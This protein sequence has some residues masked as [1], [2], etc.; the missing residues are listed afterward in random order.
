MPTRELK[1]LPDQFPAMWTGRKR[2]EFR[3]DDRGYAVGNLLD[4]REWD[5]ATTQHTGF[6]LTAR[7]THLARGPAYKIPEGFAVLS[8]DQTEARKGYRQPKLPGCVLCPD[9]RTPVLPAG[10]R[11]RC[12]RG[13]VSAKQ[14]PV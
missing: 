3:R 6:R 7:V 2:A 12:P 1:S 14:T 9:T 11:D 13:P 10:R 8:V 5:P 4:L